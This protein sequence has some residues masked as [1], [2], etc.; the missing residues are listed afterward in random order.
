[1]FSH[2]ICAPSTKQPLTLIGSLEPPSR[3]VSGNNYNDIYQEK[4][5][6]SMFYFECA[7]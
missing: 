3:N 4:Y 1:M 7:V 2:V 5:I 6:Q